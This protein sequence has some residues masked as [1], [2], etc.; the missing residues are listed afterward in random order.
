M[1]QSLALQKKKNIEA[2][3]QPE[4]VQSRVGFSEKKHFDKHFKM[5]S[6]QK[7]GST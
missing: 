1:N 6:I 5:H 2:G 3:I 4:I 7:K